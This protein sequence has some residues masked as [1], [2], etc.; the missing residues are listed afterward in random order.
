MQFHLISSQAA[1]GVI[2]ISQR[3][4]SSSS[5]NPPMGWEVGCLS[6]F[7]F[8]L[9][10]ISILPLQGKRNWMLF[11]ATSHPLLLPCWSDEIGTLHFR[12][13]LTALWCSIEVLYVE[14]QTD[15]WRCRGLGSGSRGRWKIFSES[16]GSCTRRSRIW[17]K[18]YFICVWGGNRF[19]TL[20]LDSLHHAEPRSALDGGSLCLLHQKAAPE[21]LLPL[22]WQHLCSAGWLSACLAALRFT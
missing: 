12:K 22:F 2:A 9:H 15:T 13:A 19:C 4:A 8:S 10:F 21:F 7:W 18:M 6:G 5:S 16:Q 3:S 20:S 1:D 17:P 14:E 11:L